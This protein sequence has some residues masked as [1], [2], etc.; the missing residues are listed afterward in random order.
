MPRLRGCQSSGV[1]HLNE[2]MSEPLKI[3]GEL[4]SDPEVCRF[5]LE[6]PIVEGWTLVFQTPEDSRQSPLIDALFAVEGVEAVVVQGGSLTLTKNVPA[7]WQALAPEIGKA[8]RATCGPDREPI[9]PAVFDHLSN[10]PMDRVEADIRTLFE[11]SINPALA[12]HGGYVRLV[13]VRDR[14]VYV[15]MGGGCQGCASARATLRYGVENAIR[16]VAPQIREVVD[17]TD[18]A[19]GENPFYR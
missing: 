10:L 19:A 1:W 14:D 13:D 9:S 6:E 18:H 12:S 2:A 15:E 5:H 3:T 16:R 7:P 4:T 17:V 8:I 11:E